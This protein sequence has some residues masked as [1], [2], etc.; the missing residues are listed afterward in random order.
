MAARRANDTLAEFLENHLIEFL[1][2]LLAV[3]DQIHKRLTMKVGN[4]SRS[5]RVRKS[6]D[7]A[8]F[9]LDV[10]R[11]LVRPAIRLQHLQRFNLGD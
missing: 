10:R 7:P 5:L 11:S 8:Q 3:A 6:E 2:G 4:F 9:G 1:V